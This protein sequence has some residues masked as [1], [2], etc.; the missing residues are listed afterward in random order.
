LKKQGRDGWG[1]VTF[2]QSLSSSFLFATN[3]DEALPC[4]AECVARRRGK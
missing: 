3:D 1:E 4:G 2:D